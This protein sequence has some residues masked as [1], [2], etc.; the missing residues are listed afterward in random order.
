MVWTLVMIYA[1]LFV[2]VFVQQM[3]E[4]GSA[5][6]AH[7]TRLLAQ[8]KEAE[9]RH[10]VLVRYG[11]QYPRSPFIEWVYNDADIDGAKVVWA[12]DMD[13]AHNHELLEYFKD[14]HVWLVKLEK[15]Y[16]SPKLVP[17]H[18]ESSW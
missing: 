4:H 15:G 13:S 1:T 8:L 12:R 9:G 3:R 11:P 14:R 6:A 17:Y 10:L 18:L 2:V 5:Q 16:S 7:R